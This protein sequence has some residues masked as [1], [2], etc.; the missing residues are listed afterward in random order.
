MLKRKALDHGYN[1]ANRVNPVGDN[2]A[3]NFVRGA[4]YYFSDEQAEKR[5]AKI[6]EYM[7]EWKKTK[8]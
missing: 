1:V 2:Y 4:A 6:E 5:E 7:S 3:S 8:Q